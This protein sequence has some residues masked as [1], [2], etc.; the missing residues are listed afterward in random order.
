MTSSTTAVAPRRQGF[1]LIELLTVIAIIGILAAI[2][3]P[4]VGQVQERTRRTADLSKVRE[5]GK[6]A[7]L[8]ASENDGRLPGVGLDAVGNVNTGQTAD[9]IRFAAALARSGGLNDASQWFSASDTTTS[10]QGYTTILNGSK[11][12]FIGGFDSA[13]TL[14]FI[15]IAGLVTNLPTTTPIAFTRGLK[16]DGTWDTKAGS[17]K[18]V[19]D[20]D[21][22]HIVFLGGNVQFY[23]DTKGTDNNG[24]L[25]DTTGSRTEDVTETVSSTSTLFLVKGAT[26]TP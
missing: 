14:S 2:L 24:I 20:N 7:L 12:G 21:G 19:Y 16:K 8:Y 6:A 1:T 9:L 3:I 11:N 18:G 17:G 15:A 23:R 5:I 4:T 10:S 22:G 13:S 25:V 26:A